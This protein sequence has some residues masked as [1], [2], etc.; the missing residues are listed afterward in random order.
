MNICID[1]L[2]A[3][4]LIGTDIY[5]YTKENILALSESGEFDNIYSIWDNYPPTS[6]WRKIKNINYVDLALDRLNNDYSLLEDF[7]YDKQISIYHSPNNG[8]S[9]PKN[10]ICKFISSINSLYAL[11]F[12]DDVDEKYYN[13]LTSTLPLTLEKS[14]KIIVNS[15][16]TK[17]ELLSNYYNFQNKIEVVYPKCSRI[18]FNYDKDFC[19]E[20]LKKHYNIEGSFILSVGSV[21][22]RKNISTFIN[23]LNELVKK[24]I[25]LKL[26][27]VGNISGKRES[28]YNSLKDLINKYN[29]D[30]NVIFTGVVKPTHLPIF[31]SS[32]LTVL[33]YST[34]NSYPL[35]CVE[36]ISCGAIVICNKTAANIEVLS[37]C[38][39]FSDFLSLNPIYELLEILY[40]NEAY[41]NNVLSLLKSP[42]S[43]TS[44]D[45]LKIYT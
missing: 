35:S 28:Y 29:L 24:H 37:N 30:N 15:T 4:T 26:V 36:A 14:D 17:N 39:V 7:L 31:Y 25:D 44:E 41:K 5:S 1:G 6:Y 11:S 10:K 2:A 42:I 43:S 38:C 23:I 8:F 3:S 22:N 34:Y 9:L 40:K 32:A 45:L 13:K 18:F 21:S 20:F 19:I 33:D 16:F 12:K 27:I